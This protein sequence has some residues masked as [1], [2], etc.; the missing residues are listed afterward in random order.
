M[1]YYYLNMI[2]CLIEQKELLIQFVFLVSSFDISA[3]KI[4]SCKY[5]YRIKFEFLMG[6]E[7]FNLEGFQ[8]ATFLNLNTSLSAN[9]IENYVENTRCKKLPFQYFFLSKKNLKQAK[10][11][12]TEGY[13]FFEFLVRFDD[14]FYQSMSNNIV[15]I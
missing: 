7:F 10:C 5:N 9:C 6:L 3:S 2:R 1:T 8:I 4:R 11:H 14:V 12:S 13:L 15:F